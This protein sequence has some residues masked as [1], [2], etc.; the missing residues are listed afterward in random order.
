[1]EDKVTSRFKTVV[2]TIV[3]AHDPLSIQSLG[4]LLDI[5][6]GIVEKFLKPLRSVLRVPDDSTTPVSILHKS[7]KDLL[8]DLPHEFHIDSR[9]TNKALLQQC[10][11]IMDGQFH[12][13]MC[14]VGEPGSRRGD[15]QNVG[16]H[17]APDLEYSCR[18][19]TSC[20]VDLSVMDG[21]RFHDFL[22]HNSLHW[23]ETLS[24]LGCISSVVAHITKLKS[25]VQVSQHRTTK[26]AHD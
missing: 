23:S 24:W 1:V 16:D 2:G 21:V 19:W 15:V 22:R 17:I 20:I 18:Y 4:R 5:K 14:E 10:L 9:L 6:S 13:D 11:R 26:Y 25:C 7:L 12:Q 3:L 8:L